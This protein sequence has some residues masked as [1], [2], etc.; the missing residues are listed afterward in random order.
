MYIEKLASAIRNDVLAGLRGYHQNL[1]MN[2][3][4]LE[5]EIV[6][7]R[8]AIIEQQFLNGR[9]PVKDLMIA[10][11]CV[12]VDCESLE[13]CRCSNAIDPTMAQHFQIPQVIYNFG[14]QAIDY[15]G[16][17]DRKLKFQ[18]ITSLTELENKQYRKR[19]KDKPYVWIDY[20]PNSKGML[21]CFVFNAPMLKQVSIVG[22]FKD[23]RQ[24]KYYQCC[25]PI[26]GSNELTGPD[27]NMSFISEL[28]K[29][30]LT[31]EKLYYY[32]QVAPVPEP[33]NQEY[34]T[35]N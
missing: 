21:D 11:N 19:G 32:R 20:A 22:L 8:L 34:N 29:D 6:N 12:D 10:I 18:I 14:K 30:K 7:C 24:L 28:I 16:S 35:G 1:S 9:L 26:D 5:D 4:Q 33:N 3:E 2:M 27:D 15:I 13:R 23:P 17:T 25:D 31:K